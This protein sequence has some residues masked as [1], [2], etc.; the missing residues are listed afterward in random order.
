MEED[1][2]DNANTFIRQCRIYQNI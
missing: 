1:R 2:Q